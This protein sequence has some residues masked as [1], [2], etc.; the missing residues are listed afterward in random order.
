MCKNRIWSVLALAICMLS[1]ACRGQRTADVTAHPEWSYNAVMYELNTRQFT[2]EGTFAAAREHLPRLRELGVDIIWLM[3]IHPI[4]KLERKGGLGSYYSVRDY[5][6][7]N[8]EFG[9]MADLKA[10]IADAHGLDFKVILDWV[11]NHTSRDAMWMDDKSMYVLDKEGEPLAPYDWSDVAKLDYSNPDT[12]RGMI[13]SMTY[14]LTEAD[15]DGFRCDV[16]GDVP[17]DF[18]A[19]ATSALK[20]VKSDIFMLAEAEK[21]ELLTE[22]GFDADYAWEFHHIMNR[23]A[24]GV[25]NADS[26]RSYLQRQWSKYPPGA[27]KLNFTSN[28]DENSWNGTEFERMGPAAPLFAAMCYVMP[29]MPLIYN[30]QEVGFDRRLEFF[31]KDSVTWEDKRGYMGFYEALNQFKHSCEAVATGERGGLVVMLKNSQKGKLFTFTRSNGNSAVVAMFNLTGQPVKASIALKGIEGHYRNIM[32][33]E[34]VTV[35]RR[36]DMEFRPWQF[37]ILE[38]IRKPK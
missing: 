6:A 31:E 12:R 20:S 13:R 16:A 25:D 5:E 14:W 28:H 29:G 21:P 3:P 38:N 22:G 4:G 1:F 33:D 17:T 35:E 36:M 9:T 10:F 7:V 15:V 8:P 27:I 37:V 30:G 2:P 32:T 34:P 11:A 23:I 19:E 24:Q 26:L 18:W